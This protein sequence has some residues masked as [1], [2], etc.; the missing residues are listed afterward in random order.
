MFLI[1]LEHFEN[2]FQ[3]FFDFDIYL[4]NS[5]FTCGVGQTVKNWDKNV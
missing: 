5:N 2:F 3:I 4:E 1:K